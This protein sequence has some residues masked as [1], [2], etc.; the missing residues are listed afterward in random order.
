MWAVRGGV[1]RLLA[2][3]AE[4]V[5]EVLAPHEPARGA[6]AQRPVVLEQV[7]RED[8]VARTFANLAHFFARLAERRGERG[9]RGGRAPHGIFREVRLRGLLLAPGKLVLESLN[10]PL[11]LVFAV[12]LGDNA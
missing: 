10:L 2:V 4:R 5:L 6:R 7:A 9:R 11:E 8:V 3:L 12:D 1:P